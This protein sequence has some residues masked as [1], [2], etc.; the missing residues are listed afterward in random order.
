MAKDV[1]S[2]CA[3]LAGTSGEQDSWV[4]VGH[5]RITG[6]GI[7]FAGQDSL[8]DVPS[9]PVALLVLCTSRRSEKRSLRATGRSWFRCP[10]WSSRRVTC[11]CTAGCRQNW[12]PVLGSRLLRCTCKRWDRSTLKPVAGTNT[13]LLWQPEYP[14]WIG[15]HKDLSKSPLGFPG[16]V[17]VTGH[18]QVSEPDVNPTRIRLDTS[19]GF[20]YLTACLLRSADAEPEFISSKP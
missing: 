18:V 9:P 13:D 10:G 12:G 8:T 6:L 4:D 14:V 7:R 5:G 19:G 17:Q 11:S 2:P 15:A 3:I 20:G 16:K 1:Q